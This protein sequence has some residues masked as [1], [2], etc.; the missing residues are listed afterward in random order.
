MRSREPFYTARRVAVRFKSGRR[1][2]GLLEVW[3]DAQTGAADWRVTVG[4]GISIARGRGYTIKEVN[5]ILRKK[6]WP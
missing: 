6:I 3:A 4:D 1:V 2:P 5:R